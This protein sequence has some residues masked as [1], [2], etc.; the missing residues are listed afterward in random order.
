MDHAA[1][2]LLAEGRGGRRQGQGQ[3]Q[4]SQRRVPLRPA[5]HI[6]LGELADEPGPDSPVPQVQEPLILVPNPRK[7]R[8]LGL[9]VVQ[10]KNSVLILVRGDFPIVQVLPQG[11]P[12]FS[13]RLEPLLLLLQKP[14]LLRG[15]FPFQGVHI[16]LIDPVVKGVHRLRFLHALADE[17]P[18]GQEQ[19]R[20]FP[21]E[22][23]LPQLLPEQLAAIQPG[24]ELGQ[25]RGPHQGKKAL[26]P[27][28]P[29]QPHRKQQH[30]KQH[31]HIRK[32]EPGQGLQPGGAA[33]F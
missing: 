21:G 8:L 2:V 16:A 31:Q 12:P 18:K 17:Q 7:A 13:G 28:L 25:G 14:L 27:F 26:F 6:V 11:Q 1:P 20:H 29:E 23:Q 22:G 3:G 19:Y 30:E 32:E 9:K 33:E 24:Q 4:H 15:Q 10:F 5:K